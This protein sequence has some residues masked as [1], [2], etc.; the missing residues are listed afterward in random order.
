[1]LVV[2]FVLGLVGAWRDG[3]VGW[4]HVT[5]F[6]F[7]MLGYFC[8]NAASGWLKAAPRRRGR[9]VRPF[10]VYAVASAVFGVATLLLVGWRPLPWALAFVPLIA[11]ALW[12]AGQRKERATI[13]GL[14][15]VAAAS[16][17]VP[18][19]RWLYPSSLH[20]WPHVAATTVLV[21]GYFFGTVLFVKTNI[22]ERGSHAYLVASNVYHALLLAVG[23]GLA[24][25]GLVGWW[26]VVVLAFVLVRT[27]VVPP[28]RLRPMALGLI[29]VG[30]CAAIVGCA[31]VLG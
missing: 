4:G 20:D 15:T 24:A 23:V 9:Y 18:V 16:L 1:M 28:M 22:R 19:A 21:F 2:P 17:M 3:V 26:W 25:F 5:L 31:V 29:E 12:L 8:F 27:I 14:L 10:V 7:W 11:P 30:V 13:G 6:A